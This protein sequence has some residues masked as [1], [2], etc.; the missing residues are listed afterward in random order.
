[1]CKLVTNRNEL[2]EKD[3]PQEEGV[4]FRQLTNSGRRKIN[5]VSEGGSTR[6]GEI[7]ERGSLL[8]VEAMLLDSELLDFRFQR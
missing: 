8:T 6:R 1:M 2:S 7:W 4:D 5:L 3:F